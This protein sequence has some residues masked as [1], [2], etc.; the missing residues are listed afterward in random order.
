MRRSRKLQ[1]EVATFIEQCRQRDAAQQTA[2]LVP[3]TPMP[4]KTGRMY[5][6]SVWAHLFFE[7]SPQNAIVSRA[8]KAKGAFR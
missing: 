1:Q 5:D 8:S 4:S 6:N 2:R 3:A 7:S